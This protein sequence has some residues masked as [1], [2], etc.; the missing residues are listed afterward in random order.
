MTRGVSIRPFRFQRE[1]PMLGS[2]FLVGTSGKG[3]TT[4][5]FYILYLLRNK[6]EK[7]I[8]MVGTSKTA[9]MLRKVL[10]D[11]FVYDKIDLERLRLIYN[12]QA[13]RVQD[14][15]DKC[16]KGYEV[17]EPERL[18]V[19][20]DDLGYYKSKIQNNDTIKRLTMNSR[21]DHILFIFLAQDP[22]FCPPDVRD[23]AMIVFLTQC[24]KTSTI[25][26]LYKTFNTV[27]NTYNDFKE[28][29][30]AC[31]KKYSIL[32]LLNPKQLEEDSEDDKSSGDEN[33]YSR[34]LIDQTVAFWR[35]QTKRMQYE[36]IK[37]EKIL[38]SPWKVGKRDSTL[39]RYH[40]ENYDRQYL[41]R[42]YDDDLDPK[43]ELNK[44]EARERS[45]KRRKKLHVTKVGYG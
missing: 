4:L 37:N 42:R 19:I 43:A 25:E 13:R 41:K 20:L 40:D 44:R 14:Y 15:L 23:Q 6:L 11:L 9:S 30:R 22:K 17:E 31:T 32:T 33:E 26:R 38:K 27:F 24:I 21:N 1:F 5:L 36:M 34:S 2:V 3:K 16:Q 10:P 8:A 35:A 29:F 39:W 7:V 45:R 12:K 18:V 28:V